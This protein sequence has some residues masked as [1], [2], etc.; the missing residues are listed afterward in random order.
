MSKLSSPSF[1]IV[2]DDS[3]VQLTL[4]L[5][6]NEMGFALTNISTASNGNAALKQLDEAK[7]PF[8]LIISDWN[9][10]QK[11]GIDLLKEVRQAHPTMPFLMITARADKDSILDAK[12]NAVTAYIRKPVTFE[13]LKTK[14]FSILEIEN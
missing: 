4:K 1:L 5:M 3:N 7:T 13:A 14:I 6:L 12:S 2:E 11:T 8:S 10:P 9:M